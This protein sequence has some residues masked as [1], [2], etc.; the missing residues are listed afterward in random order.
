[1]KIAA[2]LEEEIL[3]SHPKSPPA[4]PDPCPTQQEPWGQRGVD[5]RREVPQESAL[6]CR[7]GM[8]PN[9][10]PS[11]ET[12]TEVPIRDAKPN[13][14]TKPKLD[15]S[16]K[17][18]RLEIMSSSIKKLNNSAKKPKPL[19]TPRK[20]SRMISKF[21]NVSSPAKMPTNENYQTAG[22]IKAKPDPALLAIKTYQPKQPYSHQPSSSQPEHAGRENAAL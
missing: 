19:V 16:V 9:V 14:K 15:T 3:D 4:G 11:Q 17:N 12:L 21:D 18:E 10:L 5:A 22:H 1:M 7:P 6:E 8:Q 20:V 2:K 13:N